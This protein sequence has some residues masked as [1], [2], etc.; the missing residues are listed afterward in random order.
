MLHAG[1]SEVI[2][3]VSVNER[4]IP[5]T[6]PKILKNAVATQ[7]PYRQKFDFLELSRQYELITHTESTEMTLQ[8]LNMQSFLNISVSAACQVEC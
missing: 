3:I 5:S 1:I 2:T 7:I 6:H 8:A 4:V